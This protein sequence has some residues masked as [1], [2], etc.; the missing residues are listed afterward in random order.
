M[1]ADEIFRWNVRTLNWFDK[2]KISKLKPLR[3][4]S[5][6]EVLAF[7]NNAVKDISVIMVSERL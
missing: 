4:I 6:D 2:F 7:I 3:Y 1:S 5:Y